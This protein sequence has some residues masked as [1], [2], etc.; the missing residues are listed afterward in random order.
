MARRSTR[1]QEGR[2]NDLISQ[3]MKLAEKQIQEGAASSQVIT[4]FLKLGSSRERLEIK[5][6]EEENALL[7][8]K[9]KRLKSE[10]SSERMYK[11]A[12]D[13]FR[14]YSGNRDTYDDSYVVTEDDF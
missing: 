11:E 9:T 1:T 8:E 2:E 5:R 10:T 12:I 13:A 6:L 7:K 4:H 14:R 3:A